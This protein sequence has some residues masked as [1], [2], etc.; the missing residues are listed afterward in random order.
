MRKV[1]SA[2]LLIDLVLII[3][4]NFSGVNW[5]GIPYPARSVFTG[6]VSKYTV[7]GVDVSE[8]QG[9]INWEVLAGQ[10]IDFA[11]IKATKGTDTNDKKF[12]VNWE[13]AQ[14]ANVKVGAYHLF[15]YDQPAPQQAENFIGSVPDADGTLPPAVDIELYG[16]DRDDPPEQ[17][18]IVPALTEFLDLLEEH[19]G[20]KPVIYATKK[21]Y[22]LYIAGHFKGNPLWIR[23]PDSEPSLPDGRDWTF[24][25]YNNDGELKG[26]E[27]ESRFIDLNVYKGT[28]K[29]FNDFI[30]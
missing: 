9:N 27:G 23:D 22:E 24:W 21:A 4:L 13:N 14:K 8:Y 19:Y 12:K 2:L 26:Y 5:A 16:K 18:K 11:Y 28:E 3:V 30:N 20:A 1:L 15:T 25:Q 6:D 29:E 17:A 10:G 7:R